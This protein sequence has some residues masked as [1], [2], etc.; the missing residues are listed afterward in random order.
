MR[1]ASEM[2][3]VKGITTLGSRNMASVSKGL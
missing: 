3:H 2:A 1:R